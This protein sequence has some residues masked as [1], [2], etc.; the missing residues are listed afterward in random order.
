MT[1][2]KYLPAFPGLALLKWQEPWEVLTNEA[3][4]ATLRTYALD[5]TGLARLWLV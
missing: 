5:S 2:Q 1:R 3:D 4:D